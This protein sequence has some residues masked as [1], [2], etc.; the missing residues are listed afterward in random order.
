M[1][2]GAPL[3]S[4]AREGVTEAVARVRTR[5]RD[6]RSDGIMVVLPVLLVVVCESVEDIRWII[7]SLG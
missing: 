3:L 6:G 7:A 4:S 2:S 5:M 1:I